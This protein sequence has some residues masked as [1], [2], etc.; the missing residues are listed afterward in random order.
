MKTKLK[1]I[2]FGLVGLI[3][4]S[5]GSQEG[6]KTDELSL[7]EAFKDKFTVG[8]ALNLEQIH[9]QDTL[10]TQVLLQHFNSI[11]AENCMKSMYMQPKE[12]EFFFDD[13]DRFVALGQEHDLEIIGHT[14]IWHSQA[15]D[16]FFVD[17]QGKDV[18]REILI[19]RMRTHIHTIVDR[20]KGKVHGWD[21]VNEALLDDGQLR[22]SKFLEII[23]EEYIALA[24]QFAQKADPTAELYYND[25][26]MSIPAKR[27]GAV[28][29]VKKLQAEGL[30]ID[31]VGM[32][33]HTG[34][35]YPKIEEF[36]KSVLAFADLGVKVMITEF[37]ITVL[38]FPD[39]TVG[40]EVSANFAYQKELNPYA[41]GLPDS[42]YTQ[43]EN[44][45]VS[46]FGLFDKHSDKISRVTLWGV[47]DKNSWRNDWPIEGRTDYPLLFD[48]QYQPKLAVK[49]IIEKIHVQ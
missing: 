14:L 30:K 23:G 41:D 2:A 13:A 39:Q 44:R 5:C 38:P 22:N 4:F 32:Q 37:D 6:K 24:F 9:G 16:W 33:G 12:G 49:K 17:E 21:V 28:T 48:R 47:S 18:S 3:A 26:G 29:L 34:L 15:P 36:E 25:Y 35:G 43:L 8:V 40:A 10:G 7:K 20:Y 46:F 27:E 31:A 45:F 42:V 1:T 11:V 19:E